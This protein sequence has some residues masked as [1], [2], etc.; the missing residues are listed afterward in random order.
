M[1][2]LDM[3]IQEMRLN[4]LTVMDLLVETSRLQCDLVYGNSK[5]SNTCWV[6]KSQ[7]LP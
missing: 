5:M 6:A 3:D 7:I 4:I 2:F 1:T